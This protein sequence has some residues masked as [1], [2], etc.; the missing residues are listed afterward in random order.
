MAMYEA[1]MQASTEDDVMEVRQKEYF[2][3]PV[4]TV[5]LKA[6]TLC[7]IHVLPELLWTT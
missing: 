2:F 3:R 6:L 5:V 1:M 4:S 7:L